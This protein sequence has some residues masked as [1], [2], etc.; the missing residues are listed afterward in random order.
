[1]V[2]FDPIA[3]PLGILL[4]YF[5]TWVGSYGVA[6]M[7]FAFFVR[8]IL[9][10]FQMKA[11]YGTMQQARLQPRIAELNKRH[12][13]N[14]VK[15]NEETQRLYR[16]EGI[17]PM[18]GCLWSLIPLPIMIALYQVIRQPLSKM[19][20]LLPEEISSIASA[21]GV[22]EPA[23]AYGELELANMVNSNY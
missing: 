11:K 16:E 12:G 20:R 3:R 1:M 15:I 8:V 14:R 17:N 21:L 23:C 5:Y 22:S 7:L 13:T 9:L 19:M 2:M 10:P 4:M 6:L 18:S